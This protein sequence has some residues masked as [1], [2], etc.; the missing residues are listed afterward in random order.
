MAKE[1]SV[2][3]A[4]VLSFEKKLVPSDAYLYGTTWDERANTA[5]ALPLVE[6]SVRGTTSHRLDTATKNNP[7]K[8]ITKIENPN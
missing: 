3:V 7:L 5:T 8:L 6:K 2:A 1:K 4:K